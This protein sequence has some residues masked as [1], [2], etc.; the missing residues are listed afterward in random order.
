MAKLPVKVGKY[1]I[2]SLV[3]KGGMGI[4]YAA[5]HPTLKRKIILKKLTIRDK[6]FRERFRLEADLMM[7]LR[8]DFIVDMYDHFREGSSYYIA[9]EFIEGITLEELIRKQGKIEYDLFIYIMYCIA[10]ALEYIHDR[11]IVHRD[12]KPSNIYISRTG[13]VKLGD[14]GIAASNSRNVKITDSGSAMGTP[15]YMAPEQFND[16]STVD[17]RADIFSLGVTFYESLTGVK[18][19]KS[20]KYTELKQEINSGR[21]KGISSIDNKIPFYLRWI[22]FRTLKVRPMFRPQDIKSVKRRFNRELKRSGLSETRLK[23]AGLTDSKK[24]I[25]SKKM[26]QVIGKKKGII[27]SYPL[28]LLIP[29]VSLILLL[30]F[31]Y[32]GGIYYFILPSSFGGVDL[33][34]IPLI[35]DSHYTVF[36][37]GAQNLKKIRSGGFNSRGKASEFLEEGSYRIKIEAGSEISWKSIYLS[38]FKKSGGEK[39]GITILSS[40]QLDFPLELNYSVK[41]RFSDNNLTARCSVEIKE[42]GKWLPLTNQVKNDLRTGREYE[43]R[44]KVDGYQQVYYKL[45]VGYHQTVL[46][47]DVLIFPVPAVLK[48]CPVIGDVTINNKEK[49]LSAVSYKYEEIEGNSTN[50]REFKLFPGKYIFSI[51]RN[52]LRMEKEIILESEIKMV[53]KEIN[54]KENRIKMDLE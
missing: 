9:M 22:I 13:D 6:E 45:I 40:R 24:N 15:A 36:Q 47:L 32:L 41:D 12:I 19:F 26:T 31:I 11:G 1:K 34:L 23:L 27:G 43:F 10:E 2:L 46:D 54:F 37:E 53:I 16:C 39:H 42:G 48:I 50:W 52:N 7:D 51:Q 29:G 30:F 33:T 44:F 8:S 5:E 3:G 28:K 49:Y 18:P 20:E 14:F 25:K 4:V 38:P 35:E 17:K 21:Y